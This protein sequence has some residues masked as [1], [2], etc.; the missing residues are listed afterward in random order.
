MNRVRNLN[1][2][3][4]FLCCFAIVACSYGG[5]LMPIP[6]EGSELLTTRFKNDTS[7]LNKELISIKAYGNWHDLNSRASIIISIVNKNNN[8]ITL[9]F[10]E[11]KL[12]D[13]HKEEGRRRFLSEVLGSGYRA[14]EDLLARINT[15]E[16]KTFEISFEF[17][18][19]EGQLEGPTGI[20]DIGRIVTLKI[21][22]IVNQGQES[23]TRIEFS[24]SFKYSKRPI[25]FW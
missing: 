17:P 21:P 10:N 15:N 5:V 25:T 3:L 23:P 22:V 6:S 16:G 9:D 14:V 18:P 2:L 4:A 8:A 24:F 20:S 19:K 11:V 13:N 12:T 7:R 1:F